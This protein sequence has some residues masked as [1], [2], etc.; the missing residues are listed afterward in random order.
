MKINR[1]EFL[2]DDKT[3]RKSLGYKKIEKEITSAISKVRWP[4]KS[5]SFTIY[6][7]KKANG[8]VPIK[9]ACMISLENDN[10]ELEERLDIATNVRP[11]PIDAYKEENDLK[12]AVE[13]ETGNISSSHRAVNKMSVGLL[14][15]KLDVG[16][17]I[18]PS[19]ELYQYLTDRV[20]NYRELEPYFL[21]WKS[22][23][24]SKKVLAI[25]EVE[26]DGTSKSV[27]R[28]SKGTDGRA[29]V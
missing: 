8:V 12:V 24:L 17:L 27:P 29:L 13:W 3:I 26:H 2:I 25:I 11:G 19:R 18:L 1:T 10:W 5:E 15:D 22:L 28:I 4:K 9:D 21:M 16:I 20:G 6:P 7:E 23:D 14:E